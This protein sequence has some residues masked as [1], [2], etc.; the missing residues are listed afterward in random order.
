MRDGVQTPFWKRKT[1]AELTSREW[2]LLCDGCARCCL[3]KMEDDQTGELLYTRIVC[4][5]LDQHECRC[6]RYDQRTKLV[7]T[8][9]RLNPENVTRISWLPGTC[10]YRLVAEG[11]DL[12]WWHPLVSGDPGTVHEAGMSIRGRVLSEEYVHPDGWDEHIIDW[13][14]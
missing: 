10:A 1:L 14:E 4:R 8:C 7:P 9:L 11:R 6:T 13:A 12:P 3:Q 2:E 5:Y